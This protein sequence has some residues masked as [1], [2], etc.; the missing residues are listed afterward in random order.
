MLS[1]ATWYVLVPERQKRQSKGRDHPRVGI[2][3]LARQLR[4]ARTYMTTSLEQIEPIDL[5]ALRN[6]VQCIQVEPEIAAHDAGLRYVSDLDPGIRRLRSG[7]GFRYLD[8]SGQSVRDPEILERVRSLVIPPA[9]T[10]VWICLYPNGHVQATGKDA[11]GRKQYLYHPEWRMVRDE[12]KYHRMLAFGALLPDIRAR[13]DKDLQPLSRDDAFSRHRVLAAL[14]RLLD[15]TAI[16]VGNE[17]YARENES[18]GLTTLRAEHVEVAGT[19]LRLHFRGKGRKELSLSVKDRRVSNV[20]K[21]LHDLPGQSLFRYRDAGGTFHTIDSQDV[22]DYLSEITGE[23]ITAKD[24]RTWTA[25]TVA[26]EAL[27]AVLDAA[28]APSKRGLN[29]AIDEAAGRLG[30]TRTVCRSSYVHPD[31]VTAYQ[32][33]WI[34]EVWKAAYLSDPPGGL[35]P[36]ETAMLAVLSHAERIREVESPAA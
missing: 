7:R 5:E 16:R 3:H 27:T 21:R 29:M 15:Q 1:M 28:E 8:A 35:R 32:E 10:E 6:E 22:N 20:V 33:G 23:H 31:V 17:R 25:T 34:V 2:G 11:C 9:W 18:Y 13:V 4:L 12:T 26:A 30:N 19:T 36:E 14:V 24:F